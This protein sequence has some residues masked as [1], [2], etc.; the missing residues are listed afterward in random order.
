[1]R[2]LLTVLLAVL[3]LMGFIGAAHAAPPPLV[4]GDGFHILA[5]HD[6]RDEE[7]AFPDRYAISTR[8]LVVHFAW[9][10]SNGYHVIGIDDVLAARSGG[11]PLPPKAVMLTFDDGYRSLYTRVFPAAQGVQLSRGGRDCRQLARNTARRAGPV[12]GRASVAAR[13]VRELGG[14]ARNDRVGSRRDRFAQ[15]RSASRP[16]RQPTGRSSAR[17]NLARLRC[18]DRAL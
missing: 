3:G 16:G 13:G 12:R 17:G 4:P 18:C 7:A 14:A 11:K 5:Y 1:M 15:F 8:N 6:V 10:R 9:L 2:R